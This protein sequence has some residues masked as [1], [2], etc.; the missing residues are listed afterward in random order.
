MLE[1]YDGIAKQRL[2]DG[3]LI[4]ADETGINVNGKR[5]WLHNAS[6]DKWTYFYPHTIRGKV[7]MDEIGILP[8]F[9]GVLCHDHWKPYLKYEDCSHSLCNAHHLRELERAYEQDAQRWAKN[10]KSLLLEMNEAT[11]KAGGALTEEEA[12]PFIKRYRSL[13]T[14]ADKECPRNNKRVDGKRGKIS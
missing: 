10:M 9:R 1:E 14:R 4:H 7:A 8:D 5:I 13:S 11:K 3:T 6:N 12:K 2:I